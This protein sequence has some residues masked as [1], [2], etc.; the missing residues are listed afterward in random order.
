MFYYAIFDM[1]NQEA[2]KNCG[3]V[4]N[5]FKSSDYAR[6][7]NKKATVITPTSISMQ[8]TCKKKATDTITS[9]L[10]AAAS[11]S[12]SSSLNRR[13]QSKKEKAEGAV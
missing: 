12:T 7:K 2:L 1:K 8:R 4:E 5:N 13:K 9:S 3:S 6:I 11:Q 10:L